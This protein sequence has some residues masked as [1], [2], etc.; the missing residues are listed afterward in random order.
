MGPAQKPAE[1]TGLEFPGRAILLDFTFI[2]DPTVL[3]PGGIVL[4]LVDQQ[5]IDLSLDMQ[6]NRTPA[7]FVA[8]HGLEG[9]TEQDA[10]FFLGFAQRGPGF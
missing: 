2:L 6:G 5:E 1:M 3:A 8:L 7:L 10:K 4:A 9:N